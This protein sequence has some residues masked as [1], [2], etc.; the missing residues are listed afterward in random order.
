LRRGTPL[1]HSG[2]LRNALGICGWW[3]TSDQFAKAAQVLGD[4][5]QGKLELRAAWAPQSQSPEPQP[6]IDGWRL[7]GLPD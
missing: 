6:F 1:Q 7:A 4:G 3:W 2:G 5:R